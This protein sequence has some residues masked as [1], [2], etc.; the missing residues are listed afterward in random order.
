MLG[1]G[2]AIFVLGL[3]GWAIWHSDLMSQ[4][5]KPFFGVEPTMTYPQVLETLRSEPR[6]VGEHWATI[7]SET[8]FGLWLDGP[9]PGQ[10]ASRIKLREWLLSDGGQEILLYV[11]FDADDKVVSR[12]DTRETPTKRLANWISDL[13]GWIR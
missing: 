4:S 3:I 13:R 11:A 10:P 2:A 7:E 1:A 8:R 6:R 9:K 5:G 12:Y